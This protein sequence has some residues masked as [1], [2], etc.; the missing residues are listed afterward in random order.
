MPREHSLCRYK[1]DHWYKSTSTVYVVGVPT[2]SEM[3]IN[4][5]YI[6]LGDG[7]QTKY[8]FLK[9]YIYGELS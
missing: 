2:E 6:C 8:R 4:G 9:I 7:R 1:G 3:I 5:H